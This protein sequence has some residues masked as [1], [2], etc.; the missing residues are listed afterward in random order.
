M[1]RPV[2][3][4]IAGPNGS[5]KSTL[6]SSARS[7]FLDA[8]VLDPDAKAHSLQSKL[9]EGVQPIE[10]GKQI[11]TEAAGLLAAGSSFSV[12][13]TLSGGTYL[14]MA[15][16]AKAAGYAVALLFVGTESVEINIQRVNARVR[17]GGHDVPEDDQRR[18]F[19]RVFA[20]LKMLLPLTDEAILFDN[21]GERL[22]L[23]GYGIGGVLN[24]NEP[25]PGWAVP[26]RG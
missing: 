2:L 11:L 3:T 26:L 5:G 16:R 21:S 8:V 25:V 24:W 18:R 20:N 4:I 7:T 23:V 19:P 17:K 12:E 15:A 1:S 10:A 13:T 9:S 22:T 14:K 6:T